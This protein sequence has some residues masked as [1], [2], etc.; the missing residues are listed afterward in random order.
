MESFWGSINN[1]KTPKAETK[2]KKKKDY[3]IGKMMKEM[4]QERYTSRTT[5]IEHSWR[6]KIKREV[7]L[8]RTSISDV[9]DSFVFYFSK[10][11]NTAFFS[12]RSISFFR[13]F[14]KQILH[15]C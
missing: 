7:P 13:F 12:A 10:R 4:S 3:A 2:R 15:L 1:W 6:K 14:L 11:S 5:I 9:F 8:A